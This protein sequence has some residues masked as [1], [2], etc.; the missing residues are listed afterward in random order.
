MIPTSDFWTYPQNHSF[1]FYKTLKPLKPLGWNFPYESMTY[2][3]SCEE[4]HEICE[5]NHEICE[6]N[7]HLGNVQQFV[8][9]FIAQRFT[10]C[11]IW[12]V[13]PAKVDQ[14]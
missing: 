2:F 13:L 5:E 11:Q 4:N 3:Y 8:D 10:R 1:S 9:R 7:H 6:E 12:L 14:M